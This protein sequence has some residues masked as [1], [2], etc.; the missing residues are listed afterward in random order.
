MLNSDEWYRAAESLIERVIDGDPGRPV[1]RSPHRGNR[2]HHC[3]ARSSRMGPGTKLKIES[4]E[5]FYILLQARWAE[6]DEQ[7]EQVKPSSDF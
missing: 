6:D 7:T 2:R 3:L 5:E 1:A 4:R